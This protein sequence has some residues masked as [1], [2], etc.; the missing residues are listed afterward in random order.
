MT[1]DGFAS[2]GIVFRK[3]INQMGGVFVRAMS[4]SD[5]QHGSPVTGAEPPTT[6]SVGVVC[7]RTRMVAPDGLCYSFRNAATRASIGGCVE[8]TCMKLR[9]RPEIF[10]VARASSVW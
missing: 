3:Q 2:F 10:M 4:R 6:S 1:L 7:L 9:D 8:K 5:V